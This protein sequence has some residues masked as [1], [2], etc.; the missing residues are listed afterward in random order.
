VK[1]PVVNTRTLEIPIVETKTD[2]TKETQ[3]SKSE[4]KRR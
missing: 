3:I 1:T 4:K 2:E